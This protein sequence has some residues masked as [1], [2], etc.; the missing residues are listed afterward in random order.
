MNYIIKYYKKKKILFINNVN[1]L[2]GVRKIMIFLNSVV[3]KS[4]VENEN[5]CVEK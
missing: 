5:L 4:F 1:F 3:L 2:Q